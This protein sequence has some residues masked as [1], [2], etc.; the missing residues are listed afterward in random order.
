[1]VC[2]DEGP[3]PTLNISRTDRNMGALSN[4]AAL[5]RAR[6]MGVGEGGRAKPFCRGGGKGGGAVV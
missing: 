2:E 5:G 3:I 4:G 6:V 1:M